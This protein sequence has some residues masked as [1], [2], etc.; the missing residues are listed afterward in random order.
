MAITD[1]SRH[2]QWTGTA[3]VTNVLDLTIGDAQQLSFTSVGQS[4]L[5][6]FPSLV[7]PGQTV[8]LYFGFAV[9]SSN[10]PGIVIVEAGRV[11]AG[12]FVSQAEFMWLPGGPLF[13]GWLTFTAPELGIDMG[14]RITVPLDQW[15]RSKGPNY[16]AT[17]M[18]NV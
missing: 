7:D 14:L 17:G 13:E 11:E 2:P 18:G 5:L 8:T 12:E 16:K 1:I 9:P 3:T 6:V 4:A 15:A 10:P